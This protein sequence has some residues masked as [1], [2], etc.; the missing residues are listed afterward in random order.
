ML[1]NAVPDDGKEVEESGVL[2]GGV[3]AGDH[4]EAEENK[5]GGKVASSET[6]HHG[7]RNQRGLYHHWSL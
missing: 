4:C 6:W 7:S 1:Q 3:V 2:A 5:E